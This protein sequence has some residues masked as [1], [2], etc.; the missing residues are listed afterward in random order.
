MSTSKATS[1]R[2]D[3]SDW[4]KSSFS[5]D[6]TSCVEVRFDGDVVLV[7]D[8]KYDGPTAAQPVIT[9]PARNW[10]EFLMV[11]AGRVGSSSELGVPTI[12]TDPA[13]GSAIVRDAAGT[14]LVYTPHEWDAFMAGI[15]V[16]E[17]TSAL[18]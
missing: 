10:A 14:E 3:R 16:G 2:T 5:K 12:E 6:T 1:V 17:F 8:S 15:N 4:F 9:I 18:G 11:V 7:R 13:T